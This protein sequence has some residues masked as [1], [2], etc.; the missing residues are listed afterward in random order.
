MNYQK[1]YLFS[2]PEAKPVSM[3]PTISIGTLVAMAMRTQPMA[4]GI[5]ANLMVF[6]L[7]IWSIRKPPIMAPTGTITTITLAI[8]SK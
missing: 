1:T 2:L 7:P 8:N 4:P 3:R 6:S 5:A